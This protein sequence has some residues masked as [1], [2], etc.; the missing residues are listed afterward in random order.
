M[1]TA[2][3]IPRH[4]G[5]I[6]DGN[7][8]WAKSRG[9]PTLKGHAKG[10]DQ[11]KK[12]AK[13]AFD[14]GVEYVSAFI[15]ST[16]NWSRSQQEVEYL[17]GLAE[18]LIDKDVKRLHKDNIRVV[19]SGYSHKLSPILLQKIEKAEAMTKENTAGTLVLCF[20]Y[21]GRQEI[22]DA[23]KSIL[24]S[25]VEIDE[26]NEELLAKHLYASEVPDCDLIIRTSGEERL[27]GFQLWRASYSE[28][29]FVDKHWPD[30][31]T[32]DLDLALDEYANRNRRFGG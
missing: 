29:L 15:F 24:K 11:L 27:S 7:R 6:L 16:E 22:V 1:S 31:G 5:L 12:I 4:I 18:K 14:R 8:R 19:W 9:L 13:E 25:G 3:I 28:L 2:P 26:I 32:D 17:M 30:F 21:G 10:Y 20:N 23:T